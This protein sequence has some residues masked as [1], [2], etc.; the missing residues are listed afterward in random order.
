M[1]T[2]AVTPR[3]I[4]TAGGAMLMDSE[5]CPEEGLAVI[6]FLLTPYKASDRGDSKSGD[7]ATRWLATPL[8]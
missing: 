1:P 5:S 3:T 4:A 8:H 6:W 2:T 7:K